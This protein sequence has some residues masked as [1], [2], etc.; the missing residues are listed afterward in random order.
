MKESMSFRGTFRV[1]CVDKRGQV[2]W[3]DDAPNT[4]V[5]VGLVHTI[6]LLF[7]GSA[8]TQIDP[9]YVG[10]VGTSPTV[11]AADTASS[12][13]GWTEFLSYAANRKEFINARS[14]QSVSNSASAATFVIS[15]A[16]TVG[17]AFLVSATSGSGGTLLC[18]AAL[19]GSNRTVAD[20][21]TV[22][23]TYTFTSASA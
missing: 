20:T 4:V 6:N 7:V 10:L 23:V 5:N 19:T 13:T 11:A 9:W 12:H 8:E 21:D 2:Q 16:G 18:A 1:V 15:T 17:G 14:A 22:N 3:M